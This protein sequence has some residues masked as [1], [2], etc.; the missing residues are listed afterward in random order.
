MKKQIHFKALLAEARAKFN[1]L[2]FT[3]NCPV[4]EIIVDYVYDDLSSP[5]RSKV[6]K[7]ITECEPCRMLA[8]KIE[9]DL[10]ELE[11]IIDAA[12]EKFLGD[13]LGPPRESNLIRKETPNLSKSL[14]FLSQISDI[15]IGWI[16][17]LWE[18]ELA[19]V[20]VTAASVTEQTK[21]FEMD[22]GEYVNISCHWGEKDDA[23]ETYLQL[24]WKANFHSHVNIWIRFIDPISNETV[25]EFCLGSDLEG[26]RQ[27]TVKDLMFDPAIQRWAISIVTES[28]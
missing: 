10:T 28:L 2:E 6:T 12:P 5:I 22:Y 8:L 15:M 19:G 9:S 25:S 24:S 11:Q 17:P 27:L 16:S 14:P 3:P 18:P 20:V 23:Q 4:P 21:R 26:Y 7:H 13:I 1:S